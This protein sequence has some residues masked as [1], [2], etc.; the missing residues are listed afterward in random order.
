MKKIFLVFLL[1]GSWGI[2]GNLQ[3]AAND[4]PATITV[5]ELK[6]IMETAGTAD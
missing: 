1:F 2:T 4:H 5:K 3:A 6:A